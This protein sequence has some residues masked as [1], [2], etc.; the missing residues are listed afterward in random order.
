MQVTE[1]SKSWEQIT[2]F[3]YMEMK[4]IIKTALLS[5]AAL[6]AVSCQKDCPGH[7]KPLTITAISEDVGVGSKAEMSY[8]YAVLWNNGDK[9]FVTD[10]G[11]SDS[12]TLSAG[13]G[14]PTGTF[15]QDGGTRLSGNVEAFYPKD[16]GSSRRWP[17]TQSNNQVVPMYCRKTISGTGGQTFNFSSL[18]AVLQLVFNTLDAGVTLKS[19]KISDAT[20]SMSGPFTVDGSG[21][22][23][24]QTSGTPQGITLDL[25]SGTELGQ[26]AKYFN[27]S[28]PAGKYDEVTLVFTATDGRKCTMTSSTFPVIEKNAVYRITLA[29]K[30]FTKPLPSG[31]LPGVFSVSAN[32][33]VHFAKGNLYY[34]SSTKKFALEANQYDYPTSWEA[35]HVGHFFWSKDSAVAVKDTYFDNAKGDNDVLFTNKDAN[36]PNPDF[37]VAEV[38]GS[39]RTLSKDEWEYLFN[40]RP[41]AGDKF[42]SIVVVNGNNCLAIAPDGWSGEI[43]DTYENSSW[44]AAEEEGLVCIPLAGSSNTPGETVGY[45]WASSANGSEGAYCINFAPNEVNVSF[46]GV[47]SDGYSI[48]LV[49][50]D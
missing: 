6:A 28:L 7:Y 5:V 4:R 3:F 45:C 33:K 50:N 25:G 16:T 26:S 10:G 49:T 12:F 14:T 27:I 30:H 40:T 42:K 24:I 18:G 43:Q 20:K 19:I 46:E 2:I 23:V 41:G 47:R 32:T 22:A 38:K 21:K 9:I 11:N 37:T 17:E 31:A 48:R 39:Y 8:R 36:T 34:D 13:A 1:V 29:G 35:N 44:A 15:T